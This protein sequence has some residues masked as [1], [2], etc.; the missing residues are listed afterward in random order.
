[1]KTLAFINLNY[2]RFHIEPSDTITASL[3]CFIKCHINSYSPAYSKLTQNKLI[4]L[5]F[6]P[7]YFLQNQPSIH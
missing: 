2:H 1:M 7:C 3:L 5:H 6:F 4:P